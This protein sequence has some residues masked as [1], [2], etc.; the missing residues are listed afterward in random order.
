[1]KKEKVYFDTSVPSAY[2]DD[3]TPERMKLTKE[4]WEKVGAY[5]LYVS[6]L[7][8]DEIRQVPDKSLRDT[9]S[10]LIHRCIVLKLN[11]EV[12]ALAEAY[13]EAGV[14]PRRYFNDALHIAVAVANGIKFLVSWNFKHFVNVKTRQMVNLVNLREGY[15]VIEIIAPP[16]L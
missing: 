15:G 11:D 9:L 10:V 3:R 14:L 16:E 12:A 2:Y 1:M 13:V 5:A 8:L 4:F 6:T 7:V